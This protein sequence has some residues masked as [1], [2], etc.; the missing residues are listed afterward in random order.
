MHVSSHL[1]ASWGEL[2]TS[3]ASRRRSSSRVRPDDNRSIPRSCKRTGPFALAMPPLHQ[4]A[5][6][7]T[8]PRKACVNIWRLQAS[9]DCGRLGWAEGERPHGL[10][11]KSAYESP[12]ERPVLAQEAKNVTTVKHRSERPDTCDQSATT[13]TAYRYQ[14]CPRMA[15]AYRVVCATSEGSSVS[16]CLAG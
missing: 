4:Q 11:E 9:A 2:V 13:R 10:R 1:A 8:H 7:L 6:C 3:L 12:I 16:G 15:L 14:F 5:E